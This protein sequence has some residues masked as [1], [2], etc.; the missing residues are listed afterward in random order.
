MSNIRLAQECDWRG[1]Y[2]IY[3]NI[4]KMYLPFF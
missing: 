4:F 2:I 1:Y 3:F